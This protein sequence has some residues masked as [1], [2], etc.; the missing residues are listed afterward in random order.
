MEEKPEFQDFIEAGKNLNLMTALIANSNHHLQRG[1]GDRDERRRTVASLASGVANML[2]N[3]L[4]SFEG[5]YADR[6]YFERFKDLIR[7]E[8]RKDGIN[9]REL[10][11]MPFRIELDDDSVGERLAVYE[12]PNEKLLTTLARRSAASLR[13]KPHHPA[14]HYRDLL[15]TAD[16]ILLH[17]IQGSVDFLQGLAEELGV[18]KVEAAEPVPA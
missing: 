2:T 16:Q 13:S 8:F 10:D 1:E 5:D 18:E 4:A 11:Y 9:T 3:D 15:K 17:L 7:G 14:D 12:I 6:P